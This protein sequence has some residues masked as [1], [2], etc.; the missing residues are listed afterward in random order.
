MRAPE[1]GTHPADPGTVVAVRH[2]S[3]PS[4]WDRISLRTKITGVTVLL[5]TAGLTVAGIGTMTVLRSYL[6]DEIDRRLQTGIAELSV[7]NTIDLADTTTHFENAS[8]PFN[9]YYLA[10]LDPS[11]ATLEDYFPGEQGSRP[12]VT[13]AVIESALTEWRQELVSATSLDRTAQ[14]RLLLTP[15]TL[16]GSGDPA[17]LV[18][19]SDLADAN[20]TVTRFAAVFLFFAL[21]VIILG[22]AMTRLLVTTTFTPLRRVEDTAARFADGDYSQRMSGAPP[23]TEVGRLT[24]SINTMLARIDRAFDDRA[25]TIEQMRR[26]VGDASHELRTPLVTVRGYAELYRMGALPEKD[27]VA[28]AMVRI[29]KEAI[30]MTE[31]VQDLLELARLDETKP[32]QLERVDLL[33]IARDAARDTMAA[34]PARVVSVIG[35]ERDDLTGPVSAAPPVDVATPARP[36]DAVAPVD[37]LTK[38]I[39]L[40]ADSMTST[41]GRG[42]ALATGPIAFAGALSRLVP[43]S[44][45]RP[46]SPAAEP[47]ELPAPAD[48]LQAVVLGD[49]NKIRQV[50][51]NLLGNALRFSPESSPL[52][53]G[54]GVDRVGHRAVISVIDHG[55]G[56]PPQ[57]RDKIFQRFWRADTSRARE[58]GGSG[59]G[60]AIVAAIVHAHQGVVD[61]VETPGGGAS[62]RVW[63]PLAPSV[64]TSPGDGASAP[65]SGT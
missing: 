64:V 16:N 51:A 53:I 38:P 10:V 26:F 40:P 41:P 50:I 20:A 4:R 7:D 11:G 37:T 52:E 12:V 33:P 63:L 42:A 19:A 2:V 43:R 8:S 55:D 58:T 45:R 24:R 21:T 1:S 31:L 59:L 17:I 14:W 18:V 57:I 22:G 62:F 56:V 25:K 13:D 48:D 5:L 47:V 23:N 49:E 27:D 65:T 15:V 35:L 61:V 32:M 44:R 9:P 28:Q 29:E 6:V 60:L 34:S 54:V 46:V 3:S 39:T 36:I 30:R